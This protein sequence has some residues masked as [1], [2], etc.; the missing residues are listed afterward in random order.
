MGRTS[1]QIG[2]NGTSLPSHSGLVSDGQMDPLF[3]SLS[4]LSLPPTRR[5]RWD[6]R[7]TGRRAGRT[8]V[9]RRAS[10]HTRSEPCGGRNGR[11]GAWKHL[12]R[13]W[14]EEEEE[15]RRK[16]GEG[17]AKRREMERTLPGRCCHEDDGLPTQ[18]MLRNQSS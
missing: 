12:R 3:L 1:P 18:R 4:L 7:T 2:V 14:K 15:K 9:G 13:E 16:E 11:V 10:R 17:G 5:C 8:S 6:H